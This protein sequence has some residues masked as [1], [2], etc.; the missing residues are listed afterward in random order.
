VT[1]ALLATGLPK[2]Q[3]E[4]NALELSEDPGNTAGQSSATPTHRQLKTHQSWRIRV[5]A[6][7]AQKLIDVA[8]AAGA[9]GVEEVSWD[10]ADEDSLEGKARAA[11]M[12]KARKTAADLAKA[13]G[14]KLGELLYTSNAS[15]MR[16]SRYDQ[17]LQT[18]E[19]NAG[20]GGFGS[21]A[22]TFS[23]KLF[24]E[25]VSK[26]ETVRTVFAIE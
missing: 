5:T 22:P 16:F 12:E 10:V 21:R 24:P 26:Q 9:N 4:S 15:G 8:V 20:G 7:D 19:I 25:K 13:G 2:K 14:A 18:V 23:L 11:A 6:A 3:I 1:K 17:S